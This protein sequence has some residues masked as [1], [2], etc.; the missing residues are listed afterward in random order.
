[1]KAG[2]PVPAGVC[3]PSSTCL[4]YLPTEETKMTKSFKRLAA[5]LLITIFLFG[6]LTLTS[7]EAAMKK[8]GNNRFIQ[9]DKTDFSACTIAWNRVSGADWYQVRCTWTDG[10]HNIGG[11]LEAEYNGVRISGLNYQHVYYAQV[12][13]ITTDYYGY[14]T[15]YSPWSNIVFITPWPKNV[16]GS[17]GS[18]LTEKLRWNIIY[19]SNGYNVF[20]A[21][22]PYGKWYWSLSTNTRATA[23]SATVRKYRG[24]NLK[25]YTNYYIRV[26]T[27]RKRNGVFC[28]VPEPYSSYYQ[29]RFYYYYK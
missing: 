15:G 18:G 23:T 9:W 5:C 6:S 22:N 7:V 28:T 1:M 26:I 24:S 21:T 4:K 17:K 8:P 3:R 12:R 25:M 13:A 29:G 14:I 16:N 19:G 20:L 10:S 11:Y 27:R 2:R